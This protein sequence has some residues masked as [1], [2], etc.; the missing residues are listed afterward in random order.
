M[1]NHQGSYTEKEIYGQPELWRK[2]YQLVYSEKR[3]IKELFDKVTAN[4]ATEI[5]LT[6]AGTSGF[7]GNTVEGIVQKELGLRTRAVAT[8]DL[9]THPEYFLSEKNATLLISFARSG[10]SPESVEAYR[11]SDQY[12]KHIDHLIITCNRDGALARKAVNNNTYVLLLPEGANDQGLAMTGSFTSMLL[13]ALLVT[14]IDNLESNQRYV[15]LAATYSNRVLEQYMGQLKTIAAKKFERVVLLGSGSN[16]GIAREGALKIQELSDGA[17]ICTYDSFLGF[18]HGPKAVVNNKTLIIYIF[19]GNPLVYQYELDLAQSIE[20][21]SNYLDTLGIRES[22]IPELA[23]GNSI[24]LNSQES[25][26]L[27]QFFTLCAII[28]IQALAYYKSVNLKLDPDNPS[29]NG[30]ISRV[31]QGVTIYSR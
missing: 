22:D 12:C 7:I 13:T 1:P 6:G 18:R 3:W 15:D 17:I 27:K 8:T 5:I 19:S 20:E 28:P 30:A 4:P 14:G 31:V 29:R 16:L 9:I 25:P 2:T 24:L 26:Q 23:L 21:K 10:D 11:I